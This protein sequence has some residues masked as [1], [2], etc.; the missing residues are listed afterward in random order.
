MTIL[1]VGKSGIFSGSNKLKHMST[2]MIH[3]EWEGSEN[4]G[5][6]YMYFSKNRCGSVGKKLYYDFSNGVN[7]DE[8]RFCRDLLNDEV[9]DQER[10]Q[11]QTEGSAFDKLFGFS[12]DAIP[13]ELKTILA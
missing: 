11:L 6:R 9:L 8:A 7:F 10:K 3:L 12:N 5:K 2:A 1:Q 13:E 4:S